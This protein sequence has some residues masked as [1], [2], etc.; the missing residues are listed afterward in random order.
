[1]NKSLIYIVRHGE[2]MWNSKKIVQ[3]QKDSPLTQN[4]I[5]QAKEL[6]K[7]LKKIN[8]DLIFSSDLLRAK[9]TADIIAAEHKLAVETT[10]LLRERNFGEFEGKP[11]EA[12]L[13]F[14]KLFNKLKDEEKY[15]YKSSPKV[16]SDE[17]IVTRIITFLREAAITH[18]G[19]R[20]LV[21]SHGGI[22]RSFLIKFGAAAYKDRLFIRNTGYIK[23]ETDGV[24]FDIKKIKGV[25]ERNEKRND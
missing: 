16:E 1:M 17:E 8:F 3:G 7:E 9:Q 19:K 5:I 10:K 12:L 23:L 13:S 20:I 24:D 11:L 6:A 18:A 4:G 2:T 21:V 15:T 14:D 25:E 22:M